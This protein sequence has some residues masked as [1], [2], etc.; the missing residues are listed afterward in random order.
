MSER[1]VHGLDSRFCS[2]CN[3]AIPASRPRGAIVDTN[4]AEILRFLNDQQT[5]ATYRA[6]G[7][8]LGVSPQSIGAALGARTIEASWIVNTSTGLPTGYADHEM[9]AAL[10]K[11]EDIISS[12]VQLALRLTSW[13]A[14][15]G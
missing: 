12:S 5:R 6:V 10:F 1:C 11:N 15:T 13:R 2:I 3:K 9:H 7:D 4:L 8:L 14:K